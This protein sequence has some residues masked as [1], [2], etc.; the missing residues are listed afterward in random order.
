MFKSRDL[1]ES[2]ALVGSL[3]AVVL[4]AVVM[5]GSGVEQNSTVVVTTRTLG[6]G[7]RSRVMVGWG[8]RVWEESDGRAVG[9]GCDGG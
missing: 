5:E 8:C 7:V 3:M 9:C 2:R 6:S 4:G 1:A